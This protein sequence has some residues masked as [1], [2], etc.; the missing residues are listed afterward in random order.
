MQIKIVE[1]RA[2]LLTA[3]PVSMNEE[4]VVGDTCQPG[5][6]RPLSPRNHRVDPNDVELINA[7]KMP[8]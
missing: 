2:P 4:R 7:E 6:A 5:L 1:I 8:H 3:L